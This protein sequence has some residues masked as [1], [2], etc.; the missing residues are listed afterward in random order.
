MSVGARG[1]RPVPEVSFLARA[2]APLLALLLVAADP[3]GAR[4]SGVAA[5]ID[6]DTLRSRD[7]DALQSSGADTPL[8]GLRFSTR[9]AAL[10][11]PAVSRVPSLRARS[12]N[13]TSPAM[14]ANRRVLLDRLEVYDRKVLEIVRNDAVCRR[15]MTTLGVSPVVAL[16]YRRAMDTPARVREGRAPSAP[17]SADAETP[18]IPVKPITPFRWQADHL[19][20]RK[21]ITCRSEVTRDENH[22][23]RF[24][25]WVDGRLRFRIEC[26]LSTGSCG[27]SRPSSGR[28]GGPR[29]LRAGRGGSPR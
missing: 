24:P 7:V 15:L 19:F 10:G 16:S 22:R 26:H 25:V 12:F 17:I 13:I 11:R 6:G 3:A 9:S 1:R 23:S 4:I 14:E 29:G 20:R 21:S 5:V 18:R 8:Y 27:W 28:R 2:A